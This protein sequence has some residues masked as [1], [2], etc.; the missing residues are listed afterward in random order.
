MAQVFGLHTSTFSQKL[1][2]KKKT[3]FSVLVTLCVFILYHSIIKEIFAAAL[4]KS[5]S[6]CEWPLSI[7]TLFN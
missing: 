3:T 2:Q 1:T 5:A 4:L 6:F 7:A